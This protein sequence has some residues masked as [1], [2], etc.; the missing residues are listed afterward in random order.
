MPVFIHFFFSRDLFERVCMYARS[1]SGFT[2]FYAQLLHCKLFNTHVPDELGTRNYGLSTRCL[3]ERSSRSI[4][5]FPKS[6][7][8]GNPDLL[9]TAV[10]C[11]SVLI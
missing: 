8:V 3:A 9:P 5:R 11:G 1:S 2:F 7:V 10:E 6:R 4:A